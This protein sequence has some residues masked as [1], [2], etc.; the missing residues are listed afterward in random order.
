MVFNLAPLRRTSFSFSSS[1]LYIAGARGGV[2]NS[3]LETTCKHDMIPLSTR[4]PIIRFSFRPT[5][6]SGVPRRSTGACLP[7]RNL[8]LLNY[9]LKDIFRFVK[10]SPAG[11]GLGSFLR[12]LRNKL[13]PPTLDRLIDPITIGP[14]EPQRPQGEFEG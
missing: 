13:F 12:T 3:T 4:I 6:M 11:A 10:N 5:S 2:I 8:L 9:S 1:L 7:P 14:Q